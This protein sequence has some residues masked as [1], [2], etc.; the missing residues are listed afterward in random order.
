MNYEEIG[1]VSLETVDI[2]RRLDA[3]EEELLILHNYLEAVYRCVSP[4]R[5]PERNKEITGFAFERMDA[6]SKKGGVGRMREIMRQYRDLVIEL[7]EKTGVLESNGLSA[8][9]RSRPA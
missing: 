4:T 8:I 2:T 9:M 6:F 3:L 7:D 1:R 5:E